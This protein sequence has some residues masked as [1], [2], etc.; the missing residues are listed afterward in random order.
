MPIE[1]FVVV[2][3]TKEGG[4]VT[5]QGFGT[6]AFVNKNPNQTAVNRFVTFADIAEIEAFGFTSADQFHKWATVQFQQIPAPN[7]VA[8]IWWDKGVEAVE[9]AINSAEASDGKDFYFVNIDDRANVNILAAANAIEAIK[10]FFFAQSS[11]VALRD[12]TGGNIGELLRTAARAR[13]SL[14]WH[15]DDAEFLDSGITGIGAAANLDAPGGVITFALKTVRGVPVDVLTSAQQDNIRAE[16][17]NIH[18]EV[19]GEGTTSNGTVAEGEFGDVQTTID[20]TFFRTQEGV[21]RALKTTSTKVP[22]TEE[23]IA[24]VQSEVDSVLRIGVIN[25]HYASDPEPIVL[26]PNIADIP[27]ADKDARILRGVEGRATLSGAIHKAEIR[28]RVTA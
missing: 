2:V 15:D 12:G 14:W 28:I 5:R 3:V 7:R 25:G 17:A 22:Y 11:E 21:F 6:P 26:V 1:D 9:V 10:K 18:V 8:A 19:A 13:T 27:Q 24:L 20:W 16:N 23:G 4:S